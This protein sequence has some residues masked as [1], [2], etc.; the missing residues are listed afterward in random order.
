MGVALSII[1]ETFPP[2]PTWSTNDI[3]DLKGKVVIVTGGNAGIGFETAKALLS[4]NAKVYIGARNQ[5]KSEEAI[6][7][8]KELTGKEAIFLKLDLADLRAV[9]GAAEEFLSKEHELHILYNNGG[10][11]APPVEQ[12][13]ADGYD[14]QF[15]T[16]ALGHFYF[17]K[18]LLPALIST[19][20][21][22]PDGHVRVVTVSSLGHIF[23]KL[24]FNAFKDG[25]ARKAMGSDN[26]YTQSKVAN[27]VVATELA[28]RYGDQGIISV[29]L[30]PGNVRTE[31]GRHL[32]PVKKA[33]ITYFSNRQD[34]ERGALT[35]LWGGTSPEG[36]NMN[37]KYLIPLARVGAATAYSQDSQTGKELWAWLE[38]QVQDL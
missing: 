23:G 37:G 9:K 6:K 21:A 35:Q 4:H 5:T 34:P 25:P 8:L 10:V 31:L 24:N 27:V 29:S 2:R 18:L 22:S 28:R 15:G 1:Q 30:N 11:M 14:L 36:K 20:K 3:P 13:T 33:I 26:L 19:A 38:E 16:N 12:L 7:S 32:G 17:T